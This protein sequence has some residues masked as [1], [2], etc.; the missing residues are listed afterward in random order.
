MVDTLD[1]L[2]SRLSLT[3]YSEQ[4][5]SSSL[6]IEDLM[7][8]SVSE[9]NDLLSNLGVLKG[10]AIKLVMAVLKLKST[11]KA[12]EQT[13]PAEETNSPPQSNHNDAC[14][15]EGSESL[16]DEKSSDSDIQQ[17]GSSQEESN[18]DLTEPQKPAESAEP[19][20]SGSPE[21]SSEPQKVVESESPENSSQS[22]CDTELSALRR[23]SPEEFE[24][25]RMAVDGFLSVDLAP[26]RQVLEEISHLQ[27]ALAK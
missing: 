14:A 26:Y 5:A 16:S 6:K 13:R 23:L 10:H 19:G 18:Q 27:Q 25:L 3:Q 24:D 9:L 8:M 22:E 1:E 17:S 4:F 21:V 20:E 7:P 12:A 15:V 2:L 11:F